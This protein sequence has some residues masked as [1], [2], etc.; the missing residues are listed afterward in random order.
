MAQYIILL[1]HI[2]FIITI[3]IFKQMEFQSAYKKFLAG[4]RHNKTNWWPKLEQSR[5]NARHTR[6]AG[7]A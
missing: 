5:D 6:A 2:N 3:F 1:I 4:P 7:A